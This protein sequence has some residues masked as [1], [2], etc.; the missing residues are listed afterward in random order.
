MRFRDGFC[1][2][3]H[4]FPFLLRSCNENFAL[5]GF[6]QSASEFNE[7]FGGPAL[8]RVFGAGMHGNP[9]TRCT[10]LKVLVWLE[11]KR[12]G[13]NGWGGSD[14]GGDFEAADD[15]VL[16]VIGESFGEERVEPFVNAGGADDAACADCSDKGQGQALRCVENE[17]RVELFPIQ[18]SPKRK[19]MA[20]EGLFQHKELINIRIVFQNLHSNGASQHNKPTMG[21]ALS[22][23]LNSGGGPKS[24]SKSCRSDHQNLIRF[25]MPGNAF[26]GDLNGPFK[27]SI[28]H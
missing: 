20:Q 2:A 13:L 21:K 19:K 9:R 27:E 14:G 10:G 4:Q 3:F 6:F 28:F 8:E 24:I 12:E 23:I 1:N 16:G 5:Y 11:K 18:F 7:L 15:F 22:D 26:A 25:L 17:H